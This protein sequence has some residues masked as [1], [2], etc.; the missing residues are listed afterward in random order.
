MMKCQCCGNGEATF[1]YQSTVNGHRQEAHLC[2]RC[3]QAQG[4][5]QGWSNLMP[6]RGGWSDPLFTGMM[7]RMFTEFPAPGNTVAEAEAAAAQR[8]EQLLTE[9]ERRAF[10]LQRQRNAL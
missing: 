9:E 2:R 1:H 7:N 10:D 5:G 8:E 4:Y 6:H 3:A